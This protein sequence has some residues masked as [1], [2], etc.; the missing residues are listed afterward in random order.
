MARHPRIVMPN[1][2]LH[3]MHRGNNRQ[4]IFENEDDM[5]R[6][7]ADLTAALSSSTCYLHAYVIMAN[8][9]HLLVTPTDKQDL[10]RFMQT[11]ANRYVRYYNASR[12]RT[13]TIWEGRYKSCLVDSDNYLFT[14]YKYI[15]MNPVKAK[16]VQRLEHYPWSSYHCNALGIADELITAHPL[17][18]ALAEEPEQRCERYSTL[19]DEIDLQA[20]QDVITNATMKGEVLGCERFHQQVAKT[21]LR[22]TRLATHGGDRKSTAYQNQAG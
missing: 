15:E 4:D 12:Q 17:Y 10:S 8:H 14:L 20:Q 7:K 22:P 18:E 5:A 11:L 19:F 13:G 16:V 21:L 6:I 2:P 1:Q 3:I 9:L